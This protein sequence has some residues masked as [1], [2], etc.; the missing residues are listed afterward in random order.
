ME[1]IF[2]YFKEMG[3][4]IVE[5]WKQSAS[6]NDQRVDGIRK[7]FLEYFA[8]MEVNYGSRS[9]EAY[10]TS[11]SILNDI[12]SREVTDAMFHVK[13]ILVEEEIGLISGKLGKKPTGPDVDSTNARMSLRTLN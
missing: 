2:K 8:M 12:K 11:K 9:T 10:V 5:L 6:L 4:A 3:V 13:S 1:D 7:A